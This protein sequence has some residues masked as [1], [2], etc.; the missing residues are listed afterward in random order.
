VHFVIVATDFEILLQTTTYFKMSVTVDCDIPQIEEPM[1]I[2]SEQQAV[3]HIML[4]ALAIRPNMGRLPRRFG[5]GGRMGDQL[6]G[7][8]IVIAAKCAVGCGA[9]SR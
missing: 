3:R 9:I 2:R 8:L 6:I 1:D 4:T 5:H 7:L